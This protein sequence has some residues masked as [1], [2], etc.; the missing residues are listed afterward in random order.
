MV[1]TVSSFFVRLIADRIVGRRRWWVRAGRGLKE[2]NGLAGRV[3]RVCVKAGDEVGKLKRVAS[4]A[5]EEEKRDQVWDTEFCL[6]L[7]LCKLSRGRVGKCKISENPL[8]Y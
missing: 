8:E 2:R 6:I 3:K 7:S 1:S 5:E 4:I